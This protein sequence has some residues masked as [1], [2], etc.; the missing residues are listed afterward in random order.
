MAGEMKAAHRAAPGS[1][2]TAASSSSYWVRSEI[3]QNLNGKMEQKAKALGVCGMMAVAYVA[4]LYA[5]A[6][7][8][9]GPKSVR[10]H[11]LRR[12]AFAAVASSLAPILCLA[13]LPVHPGWES[14][15]RAVLAVFGLRPDH[16]WQAIV[17]PT[18]LTAMLY[19]GPVALLFLDLIEWCWAASQQGNKVLRESSS[20]V[21][22]YGKSIAS[23]ILVWRNC[24][25]AP[26]SEEL[27][28]RACMVPLLLCGGFSPSTTLFLCPLFFALAH[29]HHFWELIYQKNHAKSTAALIVGAQLGYTTIFGWYATFLYLRTGHLIAPIVAHI[30]CNTMGLP[31]IGEAMT[32][33]YRKVIGVAYVVGLVGFF[34]LLGPISDPWLFNEVR[35][36]KGCDCWSGFCKWAA[37]QKP[38]KLRIE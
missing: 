7:F 10:E 29:L 21:M 30:F 25:V 17:L 4:V 32:S 24:L 1:A 35:G 18:V 36:P 38:E 12:F 15:W 16:L 20:A 14:D 34:A 33:S 11:T 5:P 22:A 13:L 27:V 3:V 26:V 23:D 28:F 19:L 6:L 9:A 8:L 31:N 37:S 2:A